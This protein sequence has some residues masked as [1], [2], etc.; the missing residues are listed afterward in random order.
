MSW[1]SPSTLRARSLLS[2][3][4]IWPA[5]NGTAVLQLEQQDRKLGQAQMLFMPDGRV[6][7]EG[8]MRISILVIGSC[9]YSR[10]SIYCLALQ[11]LHNGTYRRIGLL[12]E[13][14]TADMGFTEITEVSIV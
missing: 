12:A 6:R 4:Q 13:R 5:D 8:G 11:K 2:D 14:L 7:I 3:G 10:P 9:Q 1:V